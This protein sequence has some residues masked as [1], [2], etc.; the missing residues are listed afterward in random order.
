MSVIHEERQKNFSALEGLFLFFIL[1]FL[2]ILFLRL[3]FLQV[4]KAEELQDKG[5]SFQL[6]ETPLLAPRSLIVDR[7]GELMAEMKPELVVKVVPAVFRKRPELYEKLANLLEIPA[8]KLQ[9][10]IEDAYYR[11]YLA[12]P[13]YVGIDTKKAISILEDHERFPGVE[14]ES[15]PMRSY[16]DPFAYS[17][18]MG[19][20]WVPNESDVKRFQNIDIKL[21][22][23]VGKTGIE[24]QYESALLGKMG[25]ES[26]EVNVWRKPMRV[27]ERISPIPGNKMMLSIDLKLQK[28]ASEKLKGYSG[29]I[30]ALDPR[31]GQILALASSPSYD[32]NQFSQG[33]S[34]ADWKKILEDPQKPQLN[35]AIAGRFPPGSTCKIATA[36]AAM[37]KGV[38]DPYEI[39]E[40][41][42][43]TQFGAKRVK[44][45]GYKV[46]GKVSFEEAMAKSCNAYF[47]YLGLKVGVDALREISKKL[48]FSDTTNIDLPY[49]KKGIVPTQEWIARWRKPAVWY[50]GD[51]INFSFGQGEI[52]LTPLHLANMI[53]VVA[54]KGHS[55]EPSLFYKQFEGNSRLEKKVHEPK[56]LSKI[57]LPSHQWDLIYKAL[58]S[59]TTMGTAKGFP[60]KNNI[61]W[62]GK[63]GS[64]EYIK[65]AKTHSTFVGFAP[66]DNPQIAIA[67]MIERSGHGAE[68]A[69]PISRDLINCYL[70]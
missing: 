65:D 21:P 6:V 49:E 30:V 66:L 43:I 53:C 8:T 23:Y 5:K 50:S 22:P 42:G 52:T 58:H 68:I 41:K 19:Y 56:M 59:T 12:T 61:P 48:N 60:L 54:N 63:T 70:N 40:C 64:P 39:V 28:L 18:L 29:A 46:H 32:I 27:L 4:V 69:V 34:N 14:I 2:L 11:P 10:K 7:N 62:G 9:R 44:C 13:V 1:V 3:W 25:S 31:N 51:T 17:H 45:A 37:M 67:V 26:M 33:I 55:Y 47:S 16:I 20:V 57:S 38:L 35:R 24:F 15:Q 36:F